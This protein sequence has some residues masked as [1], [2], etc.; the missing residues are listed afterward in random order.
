MV[1]TDSAARG[2]DIAGIDHVIQAE[3]AT[4]AVDFLHRAGRT[5][6]A[7]APGRLSSLYTES[8]K[9]LALS[10]KDAIERNAPLV[11]ALVGDRGGVREQIPRIN[12]VV[13]LTG[14][15]I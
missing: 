5:A 10:I 3:F 1:C 7:G 11:S 14:K 15:G 13:F 4:S 2:L 9:A 12:H 6:R 8:N